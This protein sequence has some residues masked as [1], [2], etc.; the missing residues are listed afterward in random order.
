[1]TKVER[2]GL[3]L[4]PFYR[5]KSRTLNM[6]LIILDFITLDMSW[7]YAKKMKKMVHDVLRSY[8]RLV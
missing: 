1:M 8:H 7:K 4:N 3:M 5:K 6:I 2:H